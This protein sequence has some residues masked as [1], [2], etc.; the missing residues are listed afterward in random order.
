MLRACGDFCIPILRDKLQDMFSDRYFCIPILRDK[1]QEAEGSCA[2]RSC[3]REL[4]GIVHDLNKL[5][6]T[7][8]V[9]CIDA[10]YQ[11][12]KKE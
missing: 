4:Q 6:R 3:D 9:D 2:S 1:L 12:K 8:S 10:L 11:R 7:G 5:G